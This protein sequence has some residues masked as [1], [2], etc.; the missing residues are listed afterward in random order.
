MHE[1]LQ[2]FCTNMHGLVEN[3]PRKAKEKMKCVVQIRSK[4][5]SVVE[6]AWILNALR[7]SEL[8]FRS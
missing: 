4:S 1:S 8:Y 3:I 7:I 6:Q 2:W 5:G